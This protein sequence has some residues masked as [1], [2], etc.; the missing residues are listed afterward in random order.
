MIGSFRSAGSSLNRCI[1]WHKIT[2]I[3]ESNRIYPFIEYTHAARARA[4]EHHDSH[5]VHIRSL[6]Y[7]DPEVKRI[8][9]FKDECFGFVDKYEKL[10]IP[11]KYAHARPFDRGT[12]RVTVDGRTF[13]IDPDGN[14]V[15]E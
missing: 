1:T 9:V 12:A 11:W 13:L 7:Y 10:V 3:Q 15:A 5:G 6:D 8:L 14:E 2:L 4:I